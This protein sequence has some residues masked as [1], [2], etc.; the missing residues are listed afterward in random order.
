MEIICSIKVT[1]FTP[2]NDGAT[3]LLGGYPGRRPSDPVPNR[4]RQDEARPQV[5]CSC[6]AIVAVAA[7]AAGPAVAAAGQDDPRGVRRAGQLGGE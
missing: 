2:V 6:A 4:V 1:H 7:S 3:V 5:G